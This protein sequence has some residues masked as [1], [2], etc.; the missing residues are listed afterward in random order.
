ME[1]SRE[2]GCKYVEREVALSDIGRLFA[3]TAQI[4]AVPTGYRRNEVSTCALV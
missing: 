1:K 4:E 3:T 2:D